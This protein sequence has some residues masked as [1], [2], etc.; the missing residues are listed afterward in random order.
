MVGGEGSLLEWAVAIGI[1]PVGKPAGI[2]YHALR[3]PKGM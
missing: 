2:L 3:R 1:E